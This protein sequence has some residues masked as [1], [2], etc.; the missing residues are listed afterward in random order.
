MTVSGRTVQVRYSTCGDEFELDYAND[1]EFMY[2]GSSLK[3]PCRL[4]VESDGWK[5]NLCV[6]MTED[7]EENQCGVTVEYHNLLYTPFPDRV[8]ILKFL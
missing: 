1:L 7:S 6:K 2:E 3:N 4:K 5:R 8:T